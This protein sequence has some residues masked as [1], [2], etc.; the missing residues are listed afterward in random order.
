[1]NSLKRT[2]KTKK[3][4]NNKKDSISE[5]TSLYS[6]LS[7]DKTEVEQKVNI[8]RGSLKD[9]NNFICEK[10][11]K[12]FDTKVQFKPLDNCGHVFHLDCLIKDM[13][14]ICSKDISDEDQFMIHM[15][16][17]NNSN[18]KLK[19]KD[20]LLRNIK[21][22]FV[23]LKQDFIYNTEEKER[24]LLNRKKSKLYINNF[25]QYDAEDDILNFEM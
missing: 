17:I 18:R 19:E 1:M 6:N 8:F 7:E 24:I 16:I 11:T 10:C 23:M 5:I 4:L 14:P 25:Q 9:E 15:N 3:N 20:L 22:Q 2:F 13:C 12:P 21:E